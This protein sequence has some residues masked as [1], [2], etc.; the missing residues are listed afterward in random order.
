MC[1][2]IVIYADTI[3]FPTI[4]NFKFI[5]KEEKKKERGKMELRK[6]G[7]NEKMREAGGKEWREEYKELLGAIF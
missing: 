5:K 7:R 3:T 2:H 4:F 1:F 6:E